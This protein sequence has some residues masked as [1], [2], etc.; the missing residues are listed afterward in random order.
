MNILLVSCSKEA[1]RNFLNWIWFWLLNLLQTKD[2]EQLRGL[3]YI[4]AD[5]PNVV[6]CELHFSPYAYPYSLNLR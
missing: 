5:Q 1:R 6:Q 3:R 2:T 4:L